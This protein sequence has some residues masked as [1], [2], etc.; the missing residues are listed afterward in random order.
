MMIRHRSKARS[1]SPCWVSTMGFEPLL[2][3]AALFI[4]AG[5]CPVQCLSIKPSPC[6]SLGAQPSCSRSPW[7]KL[8]RFPPSPPQS[9]VLSNARGAVVIGSLPSELPS[10]SRD[11]DPS[12]LIVDGNRTSLRF[13]C[14]FAFAFWTVG[15][16]KAA[17][18]CPWWLFPNRGQRHE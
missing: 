8:N 14:P 11:F 3:C 1:K 5:V 6:L 17:Y 15:N 10:S 13:P 7:V 2:C 18:Y 16:K 12:G 4:R 9:W